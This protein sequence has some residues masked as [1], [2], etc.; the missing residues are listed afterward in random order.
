MRRTEEEIE[1]DNQ[2]K[3]DRII[4]EAKYWA[5]CQLVGP[6]PEEETYIKTI[7]E[8]N[9]YL[10]ELRARFLDDLNLIV[11]YL[12]NRS[13]RTPER[14]QQPYKMGLMHFSYGEL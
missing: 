3:I 13:S 11:S 9:A 5:Q 10:A 2:E 8:K 14:D 6:W 7:E 12:F 4:E 1:K